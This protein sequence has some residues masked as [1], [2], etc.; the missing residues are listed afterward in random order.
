MNPAL[1]A[2]TKEMPLT[3]DQQR[4]HIVKASTVHTIP[5]PT[6]PEFNYGQLQEEF[7]YRIKNSYHTISI[8]QAHKERVS[9]KYSIQVKHLSEVAPQEIEIITQ[10][11]IELFGYEPWSEYMAC[12]EPS[13]KYKVSIEKWYGL[14][15]GEYK[16]LHLLREENPA[17]ECNDLCCQIHPDAP[18]TAFWPENKVKADL[19][20]KFKEDGNII[21]LYNNQNEIVGCT[22]GYS[23]TFKEAYSHEFEKFYHDYPEL[24]QEYMK[25]MGQKLGREFTMETPVYIWN[26]IGIR[27]P[28]RS[29]ENLLLLLRTYLE[30]VPE[31]KKHLPVPVETSDI[32]D[33]YINIKVAGG[34]EVCD[35]VYPNCKLMLLAKEL[36]DLEACYCTPPAEFV[37]KFGAQYSYYKKLQRKLL[38]EMQEKEIREQLT[39]V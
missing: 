7:H 13:C 37:K 19:E 35:S 34:E 16:P 18:L 9:E 23:G 32:S 15:A 26:I 25:G 38:E 6:S 29:L 10:L 33:M 3:I 5:R 17:L 39:S 2:S 8:P 1:T 22:W 30:R 24:I 20:S 21:L 12:S 4:L 36:R 28:D 11:M 14:S 27:Q 31:D